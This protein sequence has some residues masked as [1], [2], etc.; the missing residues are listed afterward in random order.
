MRKIALALSV[1]L[2]VPFAAFGVEISSI[3]PEVAYAGSPVTVIGGPFSPEVTVDLGGEQLSVQL[4]GPRQLIF[5]APQ[6]PVGEYALFVREGEESSTKTLRL[7]IERPPPG[8]LSISPDKLDE[9]STAEQRQVSL[10]GEYLQEGI[11]LLLDGAAIPYLR[12]SDASLNFSPPALRAGSY[13]LQLVNPDGK[14]SLP[15]TLWVSSQPQIESISSGGNFVNSYQVLISG[16]NFFPNSVVVLNEYSG[17]FG[18]VPPRQRI[19]YAQGRMISRAENPHIRQSDTVSYQ[20]CNTL[21]Y[22]RHPHSGQAQRLVFRISN[23]NGQQS[24]PYEVSLP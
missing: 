24:S 22:N 19:I 15:Q 10:Q 6:L 9:C 8:I 14:R 18:D 13:G 20:D 11:Q 21:I 3:Y 12:G 4:S 7:R 5:I 17:I 1:L 16:K 2:F 23:P